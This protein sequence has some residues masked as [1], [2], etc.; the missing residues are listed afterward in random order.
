[1]AQDSSTP[2]APVAAR[3]PVIGLCG[4][5]GSGKS[6]VA[7]MLGELGGL[8]IDSDALNREALERPEVVQKL[9]EW[10]GEPVVSADGR[11][12]RRSLGRIVFGDAAARKRLESLTHPLI[13]ARRSAMIQ[14]GLQDPA[15]T[16]IILDSPLLFESN[17]DRLCD[18]IIFIETSED[19]RLRRLQRTRGWDEHEL[20]RRERWQTP[21][22]EKRSRSG[23][24]IRN[25]GSLEQLRRQVAHTLARILSQ[26]APS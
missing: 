7:R 3:K 5:I 10:W 17:L 18:S 15:V 11:V 9:R 4:G 19:Q 16:A 26:Y 24:T 8:V 1:M 14:Q 20:H 6:T 21:L 12:D 13:A 25:S 2:P 23:F 22:A